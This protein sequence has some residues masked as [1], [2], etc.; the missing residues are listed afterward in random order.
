VYV[1]PYGEE[2]VRV[3]TIP[4]DLRLQQLNA[5]KLERAKELLKKR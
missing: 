1:A 5:E 3:G 4:P 2:I